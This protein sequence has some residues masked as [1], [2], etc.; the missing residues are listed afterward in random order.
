MRRSLAEK[1][2]GADADSDDL[3]DRLRSAPS[4]MGVVLRL[5]H[6]LRSPGIRVL[7][8]A[9]SDGAHFM[10]VGRFTLAGFQV[11]L[12]RCPS[13]TVR[14]TV[15]LPAWPGIVRIQ[16]PVHGTADGMSAK[17]TGVARTLDYHG[18]RIGLSINVKNGRQPTP[19]IQER[20]C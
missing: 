13:A 4:G 6:I 17:W 12:R 14:P 11:R 7:P 16:R 8:D 15:S 3:A 9:D 5:L 18:Y 20:S 10:L 19:R 2:W 1:E